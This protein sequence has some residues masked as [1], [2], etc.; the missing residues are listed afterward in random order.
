MAKNKVYAVLKGRKPGLYM[1]WDECK[2]QVDGFAGA[3]YKGFPDEASAKEYLNVTE[4]KGKFYAVHK[5]RVPGVYLDWDTCKEQVN[6]FSGA[7]YKSFEY[8]SEA[9]KYVETGVVQ[10]KVD[11]DTVETEDNPLLKEYAGNHV[12]IFTDGSYNQNT[13]EAG[14]GVYVADEKNPRI[15]TGKIKCMYGGRNIESEILGAKVALNYALEGYRQGKYDS[16]TI[17]YDLRHIGDIPSGVYKP[18]TPYTKDYLDFVKS[19]RMSGLA[20]DFVHTKGH[21]G[22]EGNEY[23]DKLAKIACD[24]PLKSSEKKFIESLKDVEGFPTAGFYSDRE[25]PVVAE[26]GDNEPQS[27]LEA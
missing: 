18:G 11:V 14:Y 19:V 1:S 13:N 26:S 7:Q 23:V 4:E 21:T 25:I 16:V 8:K 27:S 15:F 12:W 22:I 20:V 10:S 9:E 24:V 17:G 6:G 2:A 3:Q 5:G